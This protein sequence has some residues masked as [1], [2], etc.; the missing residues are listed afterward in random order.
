MNED[1]MSSSLAD[2]F[3]YW[4]DLDPIL[5]KRKQSDG[6]ETPTPRSI[7][8]SERSDVSPLPS[9]APSRRPVRNK[10]EAAST[11]VPHSNIIPP[12]NSDKKRKTSHGLDDQGVFVHVGDPSS[13]GLVVATGMMSLH[14]APVIDAGASSELE[15]VASTKFHDSAVVNPGLKTPKRRSPTNSI[16]SAAKVTPPEDQSG[17]PESMTKD[18][19]GD[20][21][22]PDFNKSAPAKNPALRGVTPKKRAAV[23]LKKPN[24]RFSPS[25]NKP[26]YIPKRSIQPVD[27]LCGRHFTGTKQPGNQLLLKIARESLAEYNG[28][29]GK[30]SNKTKI[31]MNV[32][33]KMSS[34]RFLEKDGEGRFYLKTK[35]EA[36]AKV[37]QTFRDLRPK[38]KEKK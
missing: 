3:W 28:C 38:K 4:F 9:P 10:G 22:L 15:Q 13:A 30:H 37:S 33:D 14:D 21:A 35:Q 17:S 19:K 16:P 25:E 12:F 8:L 20:L 18:E 34:S 31:S 2:A 26:I 1:S 6:D 24:P 29:G 7:N 27:V 36:R 23:A 32:L 5:G 11:Y